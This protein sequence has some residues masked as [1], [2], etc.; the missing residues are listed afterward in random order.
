LDL[1]ASTPP[2][3]VTLRGGQLQGH[4]LEALSCGDLEKLGRV[5]PCIFSGAWSEIAFCVSIVVSQA[6]TVMIYYVVVSYLF[7]LFIL[8]FDSVY[9]SLAHFSS[10]IPFRSYFLPHAGRGTCKLIFPTLVR[11]IL[12][13]GSM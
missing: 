7:F 1:E 6:L 12:S 5:R 10:F 13:P 3:Q 11:S 8:F 4:D 2:S 9:I